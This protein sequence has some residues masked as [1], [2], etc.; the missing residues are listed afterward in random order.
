MKMRNV[1]RALFENLD[2]LTPEDIAE[3]EILKQLLIE[4][5]PAS[6][7]RAYTSNQEYATI[8]EINATEAYVEIH[9][10]Q[11]KS[12]IETIIS[13]YSDENIQDFEKCIELSNLIKEI[14]I[15]KTK[16]QSRKKKTSGETGI[17]SS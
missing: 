5:V 17:Q 11:W 7:K 10:S 12:A 8:F 2:Y 14:S 15:E 4:N 9:K 16:K 13:W 3:S 1:V 6:I